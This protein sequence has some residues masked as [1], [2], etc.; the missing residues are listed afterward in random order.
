M[1]TGAAAAPVVCASLR[2][3]LFQD[4]LANGLGAQNLAHGLPIRRLLVAFGAIAEQL[5]GDR[6]GAIVEVIKRR[7]VGVGHTENQV[8]I[9]R[10]MRL[11]LIDLVPEYHLALDELFHQWFVRR[12]KVLQV[13]VKLTRLDLDER[14]DADRTFLVRP[15]LIGLGLGAQRASEHRQ[16][17]NYLG[18]GNP[19]LYPPHCARGGGTLRHSL[20]GVK[21]ATVAGA[22]AAE[23]RMA[24]PYSHARPCLERDSRRDTRVRT[25]VG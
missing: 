6:I 25:L 12:I 22:R 19:L 20:R 3:K 8:G 11:P 10:I 24:R 18:H 21:A 4:Q 16:D 7:H 13:I 17:S 14:N 5:F 15:R 9:M 1:A 2:P 23:R